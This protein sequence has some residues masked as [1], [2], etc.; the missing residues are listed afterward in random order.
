MFW[1]VVVLMAVF[2]AW[3]H[4]VEMLDARRSHSN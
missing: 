4:L 2:G 1:P 3:I